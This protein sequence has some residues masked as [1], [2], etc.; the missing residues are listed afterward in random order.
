MSLFCADAAWNYF[1]H[2]LLVYT[3]EGRSVASMPFY[4]RS[5]GPLYRL[6]FCIYDENDS[7]III[8]AVGGVSGHFTLFMMSVAISRP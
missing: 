6:G 2:D 5:D 8:S 3:S 7:D 4:S 1:C